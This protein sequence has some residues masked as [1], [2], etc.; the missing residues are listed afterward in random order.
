MTIISLISQGSP[1]NWDVSKQSHWDQQDES[2]G[3][4]Q[5]MWNMNSFG[6]TQNGGVVRLTRNENQQLNE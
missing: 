5:N 1:S 2:M 3:V 4:L 6:N